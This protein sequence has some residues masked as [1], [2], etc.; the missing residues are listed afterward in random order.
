[1]IVVDASA[2]VEAVLDQADGTWVT[3]HLSGQELCAPGHLP[4]EVVS[5]VA[6]F[7][8]AGSFGHDVAHA[9][10]DEAAALPIELVPSPGPHLRRA[11]ALQ[12]RIR[13]HDG[14]YVA[15]AEERGCA[16]LTTD[17]RLARADPPC[18]VVAPG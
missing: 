6:R 12:E 9:A 11:L 17:R 10:L 7:V 15:L 3:A 8:R 5:A 13:V 1:V 2:V 16:L 18:E 14:L 4:A